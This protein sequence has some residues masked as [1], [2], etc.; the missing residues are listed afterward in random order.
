MN[1]EIE[2]R[3]SIRRFKRSMQTSYFWSIYFFAFFF[4]FLL[5][6]CICG[7]YSKNHSHHSGFSSFD[8]ALVKPCEISGYA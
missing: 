3:R 5:A 7:F 1:S 2:M 4:G 8:L 6:I